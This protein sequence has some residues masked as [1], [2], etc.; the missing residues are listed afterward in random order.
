MCIPLNSCI[1]SFSLSSLVCVNSL[2]RETRSCY[3]YGFLFRFLGISSFSDSLHVTAVS[4]L[5]SGA[6][7]VPAR[8]LQSVTGWIRGS[9]WN[10]LL[11]SSKYAQVLWSFPEVLL[12]STVLMYNL[13]KFLNL[14]SQSPA[15]LLSGNPNSSI[16]FPIA[17]HTSLFLFL[18]SLK[19]F[20]LF[21]CRSSNW[22]TCSFDHCSFYLH[23]QNLLLNDWILYH[24]CLHSQTPH[25]RNW[26]D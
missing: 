8:L 12:W 11:I 6:I 1:L 21:S 18:G 15:F 19:S 20:C 7:I 2:N 17:S 3:A 24:H 25:Y 14:L 4:D 22:R 9:C 10:R 5:D 23:L 16:P 13:F 26:L